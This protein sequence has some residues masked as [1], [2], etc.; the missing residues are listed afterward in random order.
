MIQPQ[1][2]PG[3]GTACDRRPATTTYAEPQERWGCLAVSRTSSVEPLLPDNTRDGT[4]ANNND[5]DTQQNP[6]LQQRKTASLAR[7]CQRPNAAVVL[8][9]PSD[10]ATAGMTATTNPNSD[11]WIAVADAETLGKIGH[12]P[13]YPLNGNYRQTGDIDGSQL[14]QSIGNDAH[15]FTGIL[16]GE[17][18]TI[19]NLRNCLVKTLAGEGR[20]DGLSFNNANIKSKGPV[21]VAACTISDHAMVRNIYVNN[22]HVEALSDDAGIAGGDVWGTVVNTT[23]VNCTVVISEGEVE[24]GGAGIGAGTLHANG[25]VADTTAVNCTVAASRPAGIGA[26]R[27]IEGREVG[28]R[29]DGHGT[30]ANTTAVDCQVITSG[31]RGA[32]IGVGYHANYFGTVANTT[33]VNCKVTNSDG[34]AAVGA[35]YLF[36]HGTVTNTTAVNCEVENSGTDIYG[37][38]GIGAG[39]ARAF[40][41][42]ADTTAVNCRVG[43]LWQAGTSRYWRGRSS[44]LWH[45]YRYH[46]S[47]LYRGNFRE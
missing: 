30:V 28:D 2:V 21:A 26:G 4:P 32:G 43:N 44:W 20:V 14:R 24:A 7:T 9:V 41:T 39:M 46:S 31:S 34:P 5:D 16:Q 6:S 19:C 38:V 1:T 10:L 45:G 33:A 15:P 11:P 35:G 12:D 22:A 23:A 25:T 13:N 17:K 18:G 3:A 29:L 27:F 47:E 37:S 36:R 42:V 8:G 40:D